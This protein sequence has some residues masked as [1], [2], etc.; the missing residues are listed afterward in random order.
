MSDLTD[1][2]LLNLYH[3]VHFEG[4]FSGA[5]RFQTILK[6]NLNASVPLKRIYNLF[7]TDKLYLIHQRRRAI[8]RRH[9]DLHFYGEL[10]QAGH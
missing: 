3:D 6:T 10:V 2:Q 7:K 1:K 5:L 9:Y 8:V 4:S